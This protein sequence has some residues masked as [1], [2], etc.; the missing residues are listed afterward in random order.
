MRPIFRLTAPGLVSLL[1]VAPLAAQDGARE[2]QIAE[3]ERQVAEL[4]SRLAEL[5]KSVA[6]NPLRPLG[7]ADTASW[8]S[9]SG[10]SLSPD[11]KWLGYRAGPAEGDHEV[12]LRATTGT[13][14]T[15][16]PAGGGFGTAAFSRDSKW[17]AFTVG[18]PS[19]SDG[20]SGSK[21]SKVVLINTATGSK[22]EFEGFR[23]FAFAGE[24]AT[25]LALHRTA[26]TPVAAAAGSAA[27]LLAPAASAAAAGTDL[28][29]HELATGAQLNLGNVVEFGFD[30][31]GR[32]LALLI[33][34]P[35]QSGNGVQLRDMTTGVLVPLETAKATYRSLSWTEKGDG[36]TVLK[37]VE[38]K[39][40]A[41]K[42]YSVL[43]W[44][45]LGAGTKK[46]VFDPREHAG[47]PKEMTVSSERSPYWTEDLGG[48]VFGIGALKKKDEKAASMDEAKKDDT[49]IAAK[50]KSLLAAAGA[51][52]DKADLVIWH[53]ADERLQSQQQ[54]QASFDKSYNYLC[55]YRALEKHFV[56]LAD[57]TLRQVTPVPHHRWAIGL[58]TKPYQRMS[59]LDGRRHQDIYVVDLQTGARRKVLTKNRWYFGP[60]PDGT[61]FL[62]Y[63]EGHFHTCEL[64][65]GKTFTLTESAPVSFDNPDNDHNI[66]KPPTFPTGWTKDGSAVLLT[67]GWDLWQAPVHGGTPLNLTGDGRRAAIRYSNPVTLEPDTKGIDLSKPIYVA[68]HE[69]WTKKAGLGRID[70]GKTGVTRLCWDDAAFGRLTKARDADVF[71][72]TRETYN[73]YPDY[74]VADATFQ[75]PRRLTQ[76]NPQQDKVAWC[77]G[78]RLLNYTSSKGDKL[79]AAL[80]LPANYQ[81][82]Q[83]Y[84]TIVYI[85]ERLSDRLHHYS[86]PTAYGFNT[87]LYTSNG[88]AVL[89]PDIKYQV[90]DPGRSAVWCVLPALES[91]IASGVVDRARVGLHGHSWGGYQTAFLIT[92]TDAFKA[93][94][95]GAPL[96]NLVSMYSSI[97]WNTGSANQPIFES[98]QG[99]FSVQYWDDLDAYVRNSPVY[100]AKNVKTPLLLLHNDKD[101]AVD[102]NQGIEY[103]NTLRR[104]E[105]PVV[106]LQYKG[107]NHGLVKPANR[108]DYTVRMREFFDHHLLGKPAPAWLQEGVPHL[109]LDEHLKERAKEAK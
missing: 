48:F 20:A 73:D 105:K 97:Y 80:Y 62:Y 5:K 74:H 17:L 1:L 29:L 58:D 85:Y 33:D 53:W 51:G 10:A 24:A 103:F 94:V 63:D 35:S 65:T 13:Q 54:V 83:R 21:Q 3:L 102:W 109:R 8:R 106:L 2:K 49:S 91:A 41:D 39:T 101:G 30:K 44:S 61:H 16:W 93:A 104:L 71:L 92:Q 34:S 12:V 15:K 46:T 18:P 75:A 22:T 70:P 9:I 26:E 57:D 100:H 88:Y 86:V 81:P 90:N 89:M 25:H 52:K 42:L 107:E 11:G 78:V 56:R 95:A 47:F 72:F 79:Q 77:G 23:R 37:G 6:T 60:S 36:F 87:A 108:K 96:T 27:A 28:L 19:K 98:S 76:T 43:G 84:P 14:E 55:L 45:E 38:D 64:A 31:K 50:L 68:L 7:L 40:Y 4:S 99:R 59:T 32:W 66:V 67:D 69:E 82:G